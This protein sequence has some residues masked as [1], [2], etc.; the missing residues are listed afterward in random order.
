M[1]TR[2]ST[3]ASAS[4]NVCC[5]PA[6]AIACLAA[7][8]GVPV[9]THAQPPS[10]ARYAR[11][12]QSRQPT[13]DKEKAEDK[14]STT[15]IVAV[16]GGDIIT[17]TRETIRGG[18][19]LIEDGKI[20]AIG[21]SVD[22]PAAAK[23]IDATGKTI[24]PGFIAI[25]MS[26][27]GLSSTSSGSNAKLADSLDPFDRNISLCLGVGITTGCVQ[28]R[29]GRG[30]GRRR[31]ETGTSD[32]TVSDTTISTFGILSDGF[33][34]TK[35]FPG[36]DPDPADL[37]AAQELSERDYGEY[38]AV[39]KCCGLP[40]LP[41]EPITSTP[42][43]PITP[44]DNAVI[45]MSFG[46]LDGM[47]VSESAFLD[48]TP[49]SLTGAL[50][51]HN[52]R[53][54]ISKAR[55]YLE[56]QTA[57]EKAVASGKKQQPPRKPVSDA[58]LALVQRKIALRISASSVSDIRDM[59]ALSTELDYKL[60]IAGASEAWVIPDELAEAGASVIMTPRDRRR[61]RFGEEETSGTWIEMSR[62]L[63]QTGV[64]FSLGTL[65]SSIS[66][67]GLAG[68]DLTSLPLE[69]AFAVRGGASERTAI[70]ALTI[71][72]AQQ[73]GLQDRVGSLEVGKDAD[74]LLFDGDPLDY[75]TYVETALVN[76]RTVYQ[77][78]VDK[79]L[80][81]YDRP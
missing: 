20:V 21:Q 51:Q 68:R 73:L 72:P 67:N 38:V 47:L 19:I 37:T 74:L 63:E 80:P 14:K 59:V 79:V 81:V 10:R 46:K 39:C 35:R 52:W 28:I 64:P 70:A 36:L 57:H 1:K 11:P 23:R 66:L 27:V 49:G 4:T 44:Q 24:T 9:A 69:A 65:S 62:V 71:V 5:K 15:E 41:T 55:K 22:I 58:I 50:N 6:L 42:P 25:D 56:D 61:A 60:V 2:L 8:L 17:V 3:Q 32:S 78:S 31:A 7:L 34:I 30:G 26:G 40:I 76:G 18:T 33:P 77:R 45:K 48:L 12:P 54:Q 13:E 53:E 75:R 43:A 16:T 29:G